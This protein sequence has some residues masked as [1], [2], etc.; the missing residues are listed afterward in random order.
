MVKRTVMVVD[1]AMLVRRVV[2]NM[3]SR[4]PHLEVIAE[5]VN[6]QDALEKLREHDPDLVLLDIE[7]PIMDG[8]EFLRRARTRSR[9]K[10]VVLSSV[11]TSGSP[12]AA[13]A[14]LLGADAVIAKPSGA[15]SLDLESLRGNLVMKTIYRLLEIPA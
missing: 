3:V 4:S 6:G 7:M 13:R 15:V 14:R 12:K 9:A 1:D 2:K 11:A 10:V 8:L 5:A